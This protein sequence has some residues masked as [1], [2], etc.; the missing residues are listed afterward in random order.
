[1]RWACL[2]L[3]L[4]LRVQLYYAV[5]CLG[6]RGGL[7]QSSAALPVCAPL[8]S[9]RLYSTLLASTPD[10]DNHILRFTCPTHMLRD[11]NTITLGT[12]GILPCHA[13]PCLPAAL[14]LI[15]LLSPP[16]SPSLRSRPCLRA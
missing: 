6:V 9:A 16:M 2:H 4:R 12:D 7:S 11:T 13:S 10:D 8:Y 15:C 3:R 14:V 1:M 5:V